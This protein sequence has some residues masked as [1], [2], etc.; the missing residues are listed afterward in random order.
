MKKILLVFVLVALLL[1]SS[2]GEPDL[3]VENDTTA[4]EMTTDVTAPHKQYVGNYSIEPVY[5][6]IMRFEDCK[7][8]DLL[9]EM[10]FDLYDKEFTYIEMSYTT[11][12]NGSEGYASPYE[13]FLCQST[14]LYNTLSEK[15]NAPIC[16]D[17]YLFFKEYEEEPSFMMDVNATYIVKSYEISNFDDGTH[18]HKV[19]GWVMSDLFMCLHK[20]LDVDEETNAY[21]SDAVRY[22]DFY[23]EFENLI[24]DHLG[25]NRGSIM[26]TESLSPSID[27]LSVDIV[28][29]SYD[30]L[31]VKYRIN[32]IS[33]RRG[34]VH[35]TCSSHAYQDD[36]HF[37]DESFKDDTSEDGIYTYRINY[38]GNDIPVTFTIYYGYGEFDPYGGWEKEVSKTISLLYVDG[39]FF[40]ETNGIISSDSIPEEEIHPLYFENTYVGAWTTYESGN[41]I[42]I[43][44]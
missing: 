25:N 27:V 10:L 24:I 21:Y 15:C 39:V 9:C 43:S 32:N 11:Y 6:E 19:N 3:T 4:T 36:L 42:E 41:L 29:P 5:Q 26:K 1:T 22:M 44:R 13:E 7:D 34:V 28:G 2:C 40:T 38:G 14:V 33:E 18:C 20:Y 37:N 17:T 35:L 31:E 12:D 23:L 8:P 16:S 30:D